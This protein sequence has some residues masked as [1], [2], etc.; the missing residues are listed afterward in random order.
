MWGTKFGPGIVGE[1]VRFG[2]DTCPIGVKF[3]VAIHVMETT[4]GVSAGWQ[5]TQ[6]Y[7]HRTRVSNWHDLIRTHLIAFQKRTLPIV[8]GHIQIAFHLEEIA[9][10]Y[11]KFRLKKLGEKPK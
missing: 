9:K 4:D 7:L 5:I 3:P 6:G 11:L 10:H 1:P 2:R 8:D